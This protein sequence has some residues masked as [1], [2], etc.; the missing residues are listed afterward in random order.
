MIVNLVVREQGDTWVCMCTLIFD[1]PSPCSRGA[2]PDGRMTLVQKK[3]EGTTMQAE[4]ARAEAIE[5]DF[6]L[7]GYCDCATS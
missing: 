6:V 4:E 3:R 5:C 1:A 2:P 7:R